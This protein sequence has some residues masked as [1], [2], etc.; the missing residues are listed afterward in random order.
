MSKLCTRTRKLSA[1]WCWADFIDTKLKA[2]TTVSLGD[3]EE[4]WVHSKARKPLRDIR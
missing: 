2:R 1:A 3:A 4:S